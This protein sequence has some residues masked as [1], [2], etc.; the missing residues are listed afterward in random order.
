MIADASTLIGPAAAVMNAARAI[1]R[2]RDRLAILLDGSPGVGKTTIA[3]ALALELTGSAH[4]IERVNGQSV[5]ADLVRGWRGA[6]GYG[7]LFS[8]WTVKRIDELDQASSSGVAE[9]LSF[10]DYLP[11]H[12]AVLATTNDFARLRSSWKG[13]L[14]TRF[15]RLA[16]EAP[17]VVETAAH[18]RSMF[19]L[20]AKDAT[21]IARGAVP[22][23]QL[24]G[25]NVRAA[26][27]DA[28]ALAAIREAA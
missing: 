4:A 10:L 19:R 12:H 13:R 7:N 22:E 27:L 25:C 3:D 8:S 9:M 1:A 26:L 5:G 14:E 23:G 6:G 18:L 2:K 24:D 11:K 28:E 20:P 15:I 21:A 17:T 16:V